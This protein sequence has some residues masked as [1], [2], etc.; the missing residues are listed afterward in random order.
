MDLDSNRKTIGLST[1]LAQ[2]GLLERFDKFVDQTFT[3]KEYHRASQTACSFQV[4][5]VFEPGDH[6]AF[7]LRQWKYNSIRNPRLGDSYHFTIAGCLVTENA[8]TLSRDVPPAYYDTTDPF[9]YSGQY[10]FRND[11]MVHDRINQQTWTDE[12]LE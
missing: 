6:S 4:V 11:T 10:N 9:D 3:Q 7:E 2:Q 12:W 8:A 1:A 5:F